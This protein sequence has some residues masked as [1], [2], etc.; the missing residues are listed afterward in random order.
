M[1]PW[2]GLVEPLDTGRRMTQTL[3]FVV[4]L[5]SRGR[6]TVIQSGEDH[7]RLIP[8]TARLALRGVSHPTPHG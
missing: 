6:T 7:T 1:G 3:S 2:L 5:L 4:G 8:A